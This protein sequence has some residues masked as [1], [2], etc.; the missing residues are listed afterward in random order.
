M[1]FGKMVFG[2]YWLAV[3]WNFMFPFNPPLD[4]LL[5]FSALA[6]LGLHGMQVFVFSSLIRKVSNNLPKDIALI[7][8][9]GIT[10]IAELRRAQLVTSE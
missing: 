8:M 1:M 6:L 9:F 5:P 2:A 4:L 7:L 10:R 3:I